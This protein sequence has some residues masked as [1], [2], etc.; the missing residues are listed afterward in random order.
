MRRLCRNCCSWE[1][2][3]APQRHNCSAVLGL[4]GGSILKVASQSYEAVFTHLVVHPLTLM[5][6][7]GCMRMAF[8]GIIPGS[9]PYMDM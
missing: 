8:R 5:A 4:V 3:R 1:P 6:M 7:Y 9:F 2:Q